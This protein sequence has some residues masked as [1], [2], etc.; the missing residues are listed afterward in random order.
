MKKLLEILTSPGQRITMEALLKCE[1]VLEKNDMKLDVSRND[2]MVESSYASRIY[3]TFEK[4]STYQQPETQLKEQHPLIEAIS[5]S[6][7]SPNPN[8]TLHRTFE[9]IMSTLNGKSLK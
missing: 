3:S 2:E 6:L 7:R 5:A 1:A 8:H 4:N 9:P